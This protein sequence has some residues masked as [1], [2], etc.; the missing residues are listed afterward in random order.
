MATTLRGHFRSASHFLA[1]RY[2]GEAKYVSTTSFALAN[3]RCAGRAEHASSLGYEL[4]RGLCLS[5][6]KL[7]KGGH[8]SGGGISKLEFVAKCEESIDP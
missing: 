7:V 3:R 5:G 4:G 2:E 6:A 8:R 1:R